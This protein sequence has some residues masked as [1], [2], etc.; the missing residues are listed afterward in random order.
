MAIYKNE[1]KNEQA[2]HIR[3]ATKSEASIAV[4]FMHKLGEFQKMTNSILVTPEQMTRIIEEGYGEIIFAEYEGKIK[5]F[6][7]FCQH[8]SAFIGQ[9][10]LYIDALYVD[11]DVR[12]KGV[13]KIMMQFLANIC[14][15]RKYGRM[16]WACLDWN[17]GAWDFYVNLG[18]KPIDTL[19]LHR[20]EKDALETLARA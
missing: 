11:E 3:F 14:L 15:E 17:I 4:E 2:I 1:P 13:G 16:E 9:Y 20:L 6:A 18:A 12:E 5:A 10:V 19:T 7:F 8:V